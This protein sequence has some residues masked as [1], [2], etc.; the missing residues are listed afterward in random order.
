MRSSERLTDHLE[1]E[2]L[3]LRCEELE[4]AAK[5]LC[6]LLVTSGTT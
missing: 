3:K 1:I 5:A 4:E 2:R 6:P